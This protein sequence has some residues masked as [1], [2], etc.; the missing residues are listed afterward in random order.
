M[1]VNRA[2]VR[3]WSL[4]VSLSL[5]LLAVPAAAQHTLA[6]VAAGLKA[7]DPATRMRAVQIMKES[8]YPEAAGPLSAALSD[9]D[10][11]VKLEAID[12]ERSL[13]M[14]KPI[15]RRRKIGFVVEVRTAEVG[16]Q[17]FASGQL[18][19]LP[20]AV[21]AEVLAGLA[22]AMQASNPRVRLDALYVFG[23]LAPLGRRAAPAVEDA[24]RIGI[25][26]TIE[27][28]RRGN[29]A[30]QVAAAAVA[31]R[32]LQDCGQTMAASVDPAG[33]LCAGTGNA[34]IEAVNSRE[35]QVRRGA[36]SALGQL[37][38][39]NAAQALADQLSYYQRGPDAAAALEGL[40]GIGHEASVDI[41]K[42]LLTHSDANMRRLA[43]EGLARAG[44]REDLPELERMGQ[45]ERSNGVMLALHYASL[46]LG[47][48][49]RPD[50]LVAA[51]RD[52]ALQPFAV[53]YLLDLSRSMAPALAGSLQDQDPA[54]RT[55]VADILGFSRDAKIVAPLEAAAKDPNAET[56][57]AAQRAIE[58]IKLGF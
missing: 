6:E 50:Q 53:Q 41:F 17:A 37:R 47:A 25:A 54:T 56:A 11:R 13:F 52:S 8:G 36:M 12:A 10:D 9:P 32:A 23:A 7:P 38:Y 58:R 28:L 31:G 35:P 40:A 26:W 46:K 27:A 48:P 19:L 3:R 21:P 39:P 57:R 22:Q 1:P 30:E 44:T 29:R 24:I 33:S 49:G 14:T 18:G 2:V 43:V 55:L 42:R 20:R 51:L 16:A 4:V 15:T 45:T 34:L 5:V